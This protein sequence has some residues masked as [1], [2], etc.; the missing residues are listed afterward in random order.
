MITH[1]LFRELLALRL[2]VLLV[3][4]GVFRSGLAMAQTQDIRMQA[5]CGGVPVTGV[6]CVLTNDK[7]TV[8]VTTPGV[9]Q[10]PVSTE[11]LSITCSKA[12]SV[13][14][15]TFQSR[16]TGGLWGKLNSW[17]GLQQAREA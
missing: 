15:G 8:Q 16:R 17:G 2:L 14:S 7:G 1:T 10:V 9:A 3:V 5:S 6:L 11:D 13:S 4:V 12:V